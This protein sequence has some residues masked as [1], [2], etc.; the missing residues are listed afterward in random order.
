MSSTIMLIK[1]GTR[2]GPHSSFERSVGAFH[3][4]Q[5]YGRGKMGGI[6]RKRWVRAWA[7]NRDLLAR[8]R[9][10]HASCEVN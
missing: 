8:V 7:A 4:E 3:L 2:E 9:H 1:R 6:S 10:W 5:V